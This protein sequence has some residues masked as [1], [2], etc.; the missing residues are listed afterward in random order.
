MNIENL[1][2]LNKIFANK[3][4]TQ[5]S[6]GA[7]IGGILVVLICFGL[8]LLFFFLKKKRAKE[9]EDQQKQSPIPSPSGTVSAAAASLASPLSATFG[10][11]FGSLTPDT[12]LL[13]QAASILQNPTP[14]QNALSRFLTGAEGF[15]TS[16]AFR[17]ELIADFIVNRKDSFVYSLVT[18]IFPRI[19]RLFAKG[20][21]AI[22][23]AS[24]ALVRRVSTMKY[25]KIF[26]RLSMAVRARLGLNW[27]KT[28]AK[29]GENLAA[30]LA[31][32]RGAQAAADFIAR[33][34]AQAGRAA[35]RGAVGTVKLGVGLAAGLANPLD[36]AGITGVV[37]D[38]TNAG[39]YAQLAT[40]SDLVDIRNESLNKQYF[41]VVK[42]SY[43]PLDPQCEAPD[44]PPTTSTPTPAPPGGARWP[45]FFGPHD[46]MDAD[47][48]VWNTAAK[49]TEGLSNPGNPNSLFKKTIDLIS[50]LPSSTAATDAKTNLTILFDAINYTAGGTGQ[51][52]L[53][54]VPFI[55]A[56]KD[57]QTVLNDAI[58]SLSQIP[59]AFVIVAN[60]K[61]VQALQIAV[62]NFILEV[63]KNE[64]DIPDD[65]FVRLLEAQF[66]D[67]L[68]ETFVNAEFDKDCVEKGGVV[69]NPNIGGA[70]STET[71]WS[72][73]TCTWATKEDCHGAYPW[74]DY[75]G[76]LTTTLTPRTAELICKSAMCP[77]PCP[78]GSP[79][80]CPSEPC[81]KPTPCPSPA[82]CP[83]P[84][85]APCPALMDPNAT[86]RTYTEW[87]SK[88]WFTH[89]GW[90]NTGAGAPAWNAQ[91]NTDAIPSGGACIAGDAG[92]HQ[93]CDDDQMVG[94]CNET[95]QHAHND[96]D[97]E[98]GT[99]YNSASL[100]SI[101]GVTNVPGG[102]T[103]PIDGHTYNTCR[104][105]QGEIS[106]ALFGS[107]V[108][109][110]RNSDQQYCGKAE[111]L[112]APFLALAGSAAAAFDQ[113][114]YL[115]T[116]GL[117]ESPFSQ[118]NMQDVGG[119]LSAFFTGGSYCG[120]AG[121]S[122]SS[123]CLSEPASA[124]VGAT[125][126][127]DAGDGR[128]I[129]CHPSQIYLQG[130]GCRCATGT[131]R[132]GGIGYSTSN[133]CCPNGTVYNSA[134]DRC[135]MTN[136]TTD[137]GSREYD[138][139][140]NTDIID[141]R[142][143]L[144]KYVSLTQNQCQSACDSAT[145]CA[146]I[147][148]HPNNDCYLLS[149][150]NLGTRTSS[151]GVTIGTR[152]SRVVCPVGTTRGSDLRTCCQAGST[153]TG[154]TGLC[155]PPGSTGGSDGQ[156]C[157]PAGSTFTGVTG[158]CCPT[159]KNLSS[160][161]QTCGTPVNAVCTYSSCFPSC[162]TSASK[163][164]IS[165]T[166]A[167]FGGADC[168]TGFPVGGNIPCTDLPACQPSSSFPYT[169]VTSLSELTDQYTSKTPV[170]PNLT[171][172][173]AAAACTSL[174]W[175]RYFSLNRNGDA[176]FFAYLSNI[177]AFP[178]VGAAGYTDTVL[179][180]KN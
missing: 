69:F 60:L 136:R 94:M 109:R 38:M 165:K 18:D 92:F 22:G 75:D 152:S 62:S 179:Y 1:E 153:F 19:I 3:K 178:M 131:Y 135:D 25:R 66:T 29:L 126:W 59:Q 100:C 130:E 128:H 49:L 52:D 148:H 125:V 41:D 72:S 81:W 15:I 63:F 175:C 85:A 117:I 53:V 28:S 122:G 80:P 91:L 34:A 177:D 12:P 167:S 132:V 114:E 74:F 151:S 88:D 172:D 55:W 32:E 83:Q 35:A 14:E 156:T 9:D 64:G 106:Q 7:L 99:C 162:G 71:S 155:C 16:D 166:P 2:N 51:V 107:T 43:E 138:L 170:I 86:D 118:S 113:Q 33:G 168:A 23:K 108:M 147:I 104:D 123:V 27:Q 173:V 82:P 90:I 95:M 96:Y 70:G 163:T 30:K 39:N 159:G 87:R 133:R 142:A 79:A 36:V 154:V 134:A 176:V 129:C 143:V 10:S 157:C 48:L 110:L 17:I 116:Q 45:V 8:L 111:E 146:G 37:L 40:T 65:A 67:E 58:V 73:H 149:D 47:Y 150:M 121:C 26:S 44:A 115:F 24:A 103:D 6:D 169:Q 84:P 140:D 93:I 119:A 5:D 89:S 42:C 78:A 101:K 139:I 160:D 57:S 124:A 13:N 105:D 61:I 141:T 137:T 171:L 158:K 56:C 180:K 98:R 68:I 120:T 11:I 4:P 127:Y 31:R 144:G 161:G 102:F 54:S 174:D 20:L 77:A 21:V 97:R 76:N 50:T 164:L 112:V 46:L 145:A